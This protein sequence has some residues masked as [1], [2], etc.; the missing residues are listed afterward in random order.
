M[1]RAKVRWSPVEVDY[2][3]AHREDAKDQ[4]CIA[5]GKTRNAIQKKLR[6]LD[7]KS[8]AADKVNV[9]FQSKVGLRDDLGIF[10]RSAWEANMMRLFKSGKYKLT[11][12]EY[13]P[14]IF[15]FTDHV[16]P[17]GA[18]LSYMPDFQV[19]KG[20][21]KFWVEVKGNWLRG[22]DKTKLRR[23]KKFYP[24]EFKKLIAVV[25]SKTSK[26]YKFFEELGVPDDQILEYNQLKK[27][28][29]KQV[30]HWEP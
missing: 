15:S 29:G 13:E 11:A 3:K 25:S 5:L 18:A 19:S 24:E 4:L 1:F 12:P 20:K 21:K 27:E 16:P 8:T 6:E 26:T 28:F 7:G 23:F 9:A 2:L 14:K 22:S 10:V 30:E 17:K